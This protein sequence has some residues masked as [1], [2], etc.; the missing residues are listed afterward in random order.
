MS[1]LVRRLGRI[2]PETTCLL[3][4]DMQEK[5]RPN[6]AFF[7]AIV[8][9]SNRVL[10]AANIMSVPVMATEQ[11]PKGL[12]STVPEIELAK[13][14]VKPVAKTCFTMAIP[15]LLNQMAP[16][17]R[18]VILCGIEA[19]ACIQHTALDLLAKQQPELDVHVVVDCVSSRSMTDRMYALNRMRDSGAFLTTSECV[20]LGL[21]GDS[22]HPKFRDLQKLVMES[23]KDTGLLRANM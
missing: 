15:E 6:I 7:D 9:N 10:H 23:A 21:A 19:H 12:G 11:Y 13:F 22:A 1:S 4:C 5:F 14:G 8:H 18:S 17:T 3:L 20:I 16:E 2:N